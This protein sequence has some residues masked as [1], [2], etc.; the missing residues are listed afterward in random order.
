MPKRIR[1]NAFELNSVVHQSPG[2][3]RHPRDQSADYM[4]IEPWVELARTSER[5]LARRVWRP[6]IRRRNFDFG[7]EE[8]C[9][10][11]KKGKALP[12]FRSRHDAAAAFH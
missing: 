6:H 7:I 2:L 8:S 3:W 5:E 1:F 9:S 11:L 4:H 10:I 12:S